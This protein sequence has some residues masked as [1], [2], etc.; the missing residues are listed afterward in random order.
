[1]L[2]AVIYHAMI[3]TTLC[4]PAPLK[5][6][7]VTQQGCTM[8]TTLDLHGI[9]HKDVSLLVENFILTNEMPVKIITGNS[10][11]MKQLVLDILR[12]HGFTHRQLSDYN[13]GE[14]IVF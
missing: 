3:A 5:H 14:Y 1:M 8:T 4:S 12:Q 7:L 9:Q 2:P 6:H 13:L 11:T 10:N